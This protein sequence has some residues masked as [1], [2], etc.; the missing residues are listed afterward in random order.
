M[1]II[2]G[3]NSTLSI[4]GVNLSIGVSPNEI[5]ILY[6]GIPTNREKMLILFNETALS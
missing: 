5:Q 1:E 4:G 6:C 2:I 3:Q